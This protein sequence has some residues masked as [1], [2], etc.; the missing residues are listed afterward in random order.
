[1][2][3]EARGTTPWL[4]DGASVPQQQTIRDFGRSRAKALKDVRDRLPVH[5]RA[6]MPGCKKKREAL[7][8]LNCTRR[9]FRLKDGRLHLAG[10]IVLT[11]V[12]SRALPADPSSVRVHRDAVGHWWASFVVP[13]EVRPLPATG[14]VLGVDWGVRE[15]ATTTSDAHDLPHP[16]HG[17]KAPGEAD[18]VRPDDGPPQTEE[19]T[20]R[21]E[22]LPRGE[23][24][25]GEDL[26][27][28]RPAASGHGA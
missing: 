28:D 9:G 5:R 18:P 10:G 13:A 24:V 4:R 6:G 27:E 19:G 20:D 23:E 14:A 15:I 7:P 8:T 17:R 22:G 25:A 1:M 2:L 26:R 11:V 16:Q 12:W 3:T 21:L